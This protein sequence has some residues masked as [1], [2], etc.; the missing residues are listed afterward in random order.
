M[1]R[2]TTGG[3]TSTVNET[4]IGI[5]PGKTTGLFKWHRG[6]LTHV[7]HGEVKDWRDVPKTVVELDGDIWVY[8]RFLI[9]PQ[10]LKKA[11]QYE[12]LYAIGALEHEAHRLGQ[13]I[14][15]QTPQ[16][17]LAASD[18]VLKHLGWWYPGM[19][20]SMDAARHV[21]IFALRL[22]WITIEEIKG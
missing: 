4:I 16:T 20:H 5:D 1:D 11:R 6:D 18:D 22:G 10:T 8:E 15:G 21:L 13:E 12:P 2:S 14:H 17:R 7:V 9:G 3:V 19:Q